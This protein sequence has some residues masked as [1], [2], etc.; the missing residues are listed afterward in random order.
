MPINV[1]QGD[2]SDTPPDRELVCTRAGIRGWEEAGEKARTFLGGETNSLDCVRIYVTARRASIYAHSNFA[3]KDSLFESKVLVSNKRSLDTI[4]INLVATSEDLSSLEFGHDFRKALAEHFMFFVEEQVL[5]KEQYPNLQFSG[6]KN[7]MV[8]D[9][10]QR[11]LPLDEWEEQM[12][13][14]RSR[15]PSGQLN[16]WISGSFYLVTFVAIIAAIRFVSGPLKLLAVP[17]VLVGSLLI[18]AVVGA[19]TLRNQGLLHEDRFLELV[20]VTLNQ[21]PLVAHLLP[22][23]KSKSRDSPQRS[24]Q[25]SQGPE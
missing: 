20:K 12:T 10:H 15:A 1:Q 16:P 13:Q 8:V 6:I 25:T 19:F 4:A 18:F 2:L 3:K 9:K 23:G 7:V 21:L 17:A 5:D 24:N 22:F 11:V 14:K